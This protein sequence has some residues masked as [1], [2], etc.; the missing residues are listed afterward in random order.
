LIESLYYGETVACQV[1]IPRL[2]IEEMTGEVDTKYV[3]LVHQQARRALVEKLIEQLQIEEKQIDD[4]KTD[5]IIYTFVWRPKSK[6]HQIIHQPTP[7]DYP[8]LWAPSPAPDPT[9]SEMP[10]VVITLNPPRKLKL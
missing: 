10:S 4:W 9:E 3:E 2:M 5:E 8:P 7:E 1:R 6:K